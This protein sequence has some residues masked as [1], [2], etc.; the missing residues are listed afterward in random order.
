MLNLQVLDWLDENSLRW[1]PLK[2]TVDNAV[3]MIPS[4]TDDNGL[5][6]QTTG[7]AKFN[8]FR[9]LIAVGDVV[10][11]LDSATQYTVTAINLAGSH[12]TVDPAPAS[13]LSSRAF[14]IIKAQG[15]LAGVDENKDNA[16]DLSNASLQS[17]I[18][19]ANLVFLTKLTGEIQLYSITL[20]TDAVITVA[21]NNEAIQTFTV[22]AYLS[23]TYPYYCRNAD[24][25]LLVFGESLK[26]IKRNLVFEN[27]FF[28]NSVCH[29]FYGKWAGVTSLG[30]N[31]TPLGGDIDF[32]D[33]Y[34]FKTEVSEADNSVFLG[35]RS[36]YGDPLPCDSFFSDI[37][38]A[39]CSE[40]ISSINGVRPAT[41][42][43]DFKLTAGDNV[44]IFPD[45]EHNRI[46]LG[47]SFK[48]ADI[49]KPRAALPNPN[50]T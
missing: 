34:Q 13:T 28:E 19:D 15:L 25:S 9:E 1:Y 3:S 22:P 48:A 41:N 10:Q 38:T 36:N 16:T 47:L 43:G 17:T 32:T 46:F 18:L 8:N 14:R 26:L 40:L 35:A 33:G 39:P 11:F 4:S 23:A 37:A 20:G 27:I 5:N 12:F 49:C 30:F 21:H 7:F 2:Q 42:F 50:I 24:G 29:Y 31:G 6:I 45:K 44:A